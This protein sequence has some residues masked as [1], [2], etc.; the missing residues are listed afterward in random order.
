MQKGLAGSIDLS[1]KADKEKSPLRQATLR[2]WMRAAIR[3]Q[4]QGRCQCG[5]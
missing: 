2:R 3:G 1:G 4:R 5:S